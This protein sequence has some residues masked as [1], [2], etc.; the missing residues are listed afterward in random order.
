MYL[1]KICSLWEAKFNFT[2]FFHT[3]LQKKECWNISLTHVIVCRAHVGSSTVVCHLFLTLWWLGGCQSK[4]FRRWR[5]CKT[6]F[7][8]PYICH[9]LW[10][11]VF[12]S[13]RVWVKGTGWPWSCHWRCAETHYSHLLDHLTWTVCLSRCWWCENDKYTECETALDPIYRFD[14]SAYHRPPRT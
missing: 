6:Y 10:L 12:M 11:W 2:H 14:S 8:A 13:S 7:K 9:I 1:T 4:S 5:I 3:V